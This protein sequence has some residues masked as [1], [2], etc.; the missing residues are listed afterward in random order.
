L[1]FGN[2]E[3]EKNFFKNELWKGKSKEE[4]KE[5]K[6]RR[7]GGRRKDCTFTFFSVRYVS[8]SSDILLMSRGKK[9]NVD[10]GKKK[11][12]RREK[13]LERNQKKKREKKEKKKEKRE[14]RKRKP[15]SLFV[16]KTT[17]RR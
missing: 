5:T 16:C 13:E 1:G 7:R 2:N 12:E 15:L 4:K 17:K 14:K 9:E 6:E 10:K 11:K 8:D 3:V